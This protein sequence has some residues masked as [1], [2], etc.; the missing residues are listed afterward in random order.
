MSQ[1][2]HVGLNFTPSP[3]AAS[4]FQLLPSIVAY[5]C[6]HCFSFSG[7]SLFRVRNLMSLTPSCSWGHNESPAWVPELSPDVQKHMTN[8]AA[9]NPSQPFPSPI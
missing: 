3:H 1:G 6:R 8:T 7:L 5:F 9:E 4:F 2:C